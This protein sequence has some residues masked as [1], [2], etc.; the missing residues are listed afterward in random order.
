MLLRFNKLTRA[1]QF[2]GS[3]NATYYLKADEQVTTES[4][5]VTRLERLFY[6]P[7]FRYRLSSAWARAS[8]SLAASVNYTKRYIN[9]SVD[10]PEVVGA[11][12]TVDAQVSFAPVSLW[13]GSFRISLSAINVLDER[14][15]EVNTPLYPGGVQFGF[16]AANASPIGRFV[17]LQ[18]SKRW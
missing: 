3:L 7:S 15:P 4:A 5:T 13:D 1:G 17:T 8:W 2:S 11:Y 14:P 6:L 18:L 9:D 12:T 10:P 16:D